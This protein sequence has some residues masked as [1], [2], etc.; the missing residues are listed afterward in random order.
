MSPLRRRSIGSSCD[1]VRHALHEHKLKWD[2]VGTEVVERDSAELHAEVV[3]PALIL[4]QGRPRFADVNREY[5]NALDELGER[6]WA[7]A[8]ADANGAV[9]TTLRI[10]TGLEQGHLPALL[11]E[12][13]RRAIF[14]PEEDGRLR[15]FVEGF[16]ALSDMR[17]QEGDSYAHA[18]T[19][20]AAWL[21]VHWAGALIVFIVERVDELEM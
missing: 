6:N 19:R 16:T 21:A 14:G 2:I 9:E 12:A 1:T 8:I 13:R 11:D 7:A 5:K 3:V 15:K 18:G 4:I 20:D 10:V 17:S